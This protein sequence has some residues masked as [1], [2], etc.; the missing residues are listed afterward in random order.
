MGRLGSGKFAAEKQELIC[1]THTQ[2]LF[3][4]MDSHVLLDLHVALRID[5]KIS[6]PIVNQLP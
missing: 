2:A 5:T 1:V 3:I 6:N 4:S